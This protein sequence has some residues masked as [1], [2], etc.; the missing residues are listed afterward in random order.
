MSL[1]TNCCNAILIFHN[2][3]QYCATETTVVPLYRGDLISQ[4][5]NSPSACSYFYYTRPPTQV[6]LFSQSGVAY[7]LYHHLPT[8]RDHLLFFRIAFV[9]I[10][11]CIR[12]DHIHRVASRRLSFTITIST[13]Q[14]GIRNG[15]T[16]G[17]MLNGTGRPGGGL[18]RDA[19]YHQG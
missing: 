15:G 6:R 17:P 5:H 18:H 16:V 2:A 4:K 10:F 9:E 8:V 11:D 1:S 12:R 14:F 7:H 19:L 13:V 3:A